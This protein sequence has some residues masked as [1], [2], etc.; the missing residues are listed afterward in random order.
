L[1]AVDASTGTE[2]QYGKV[3]ESRDSL[4]RWYLAKESLARFPALGLVLEYV[5]KEGIER[6][7]SFG[8]GCC[9]LE[10]L[11]KAALPESAIVVASDFDAF[12]IARA[13]ELFP[14]ITPVEFDF[15]SEDPAR[16]QEC[17]DVRFDLAVFFGSTAHMDDAEFVGFWTKL[18]EA[19]IRRVID[20]QAGHIRTRSVLRYHAGRVKAALR[21]RLSTGYGE[22]ITAYARTTRELRGLYHQAGFRPV[23]ETSLGG[24]RYCAICIAQ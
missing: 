4:L 16:L 10:H 21:R 7:V 3:Y 18:R 15:R 19:G 24:Y 9:V 23:L 13:R 20:F 2:R 1:T 17:V 5:Y 12:A 22:R 14:S 8:A 6:I 11:I